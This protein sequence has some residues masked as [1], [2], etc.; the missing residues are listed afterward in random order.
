RLAEVA[1]ELST[2]D[3]ALDSLAREQAETEAERERSQGHLD[4]LSSAG[5]P[6]EQAVEE[7]KDAVVAAVAEESRLHNLAEALRRR[8]GELEGQRRQL[9]HEQHPPR[10]PFAHNARPRH[11]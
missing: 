6:L 11:H 7:A 2:L 10:P 5:A 1:G 4:E 9:D 3:G 8:R